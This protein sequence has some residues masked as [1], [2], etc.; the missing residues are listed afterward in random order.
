M[1]APRGDQSLQRLNYNREAKNFV[2]T[3]ADYQVNRTLR[4]QSKVERAVVKVKNDAPKFEYIGTPLKVH[5]TTFAMN[6]KYLGVVVLD[7]SSKSITG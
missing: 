4:K 5:N 2:W 6:S 3:L 1:H 7:P